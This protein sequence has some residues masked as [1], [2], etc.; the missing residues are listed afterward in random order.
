MHKL[1]HETVKEGPFY[2]LGHSSSPME[3]FC[4][5]PH[6]KLLRVSRIRNLY[7]LR[8]VQDQPVSFLGH[9][10]FSAWI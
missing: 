7:A 6:T 10:P 9:D 3:G 8:P 1:M 2:R 5:G 4:G